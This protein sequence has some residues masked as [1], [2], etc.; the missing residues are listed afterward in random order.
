MGKIS[1]RRETE[2]VAP[3][4]HA[5]YCKKSKTA[6]TMLTFFEYTFGL[7]AAVCWQRAVGSELIELNATQGYLVE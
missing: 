6:S 7:R 1:G 4:I 2:E 3:L 5:A